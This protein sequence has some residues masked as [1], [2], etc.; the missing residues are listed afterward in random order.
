MRLSFL[1]LLCALLLP[2]PASA[3]SLPSI[4]VRDAY[5]K[6]SLAGVTTGV[7]F[8]TISSHHEDSV[9]SVS[10]PAAQSA[11]LHDH[12]HEG[13]MMRMRK[14]DSVALVPGKPV[15]FRPGGLHVMLFGVSPALKEG[16]TIALT[17]TFAHSDPVTIEV[18]VREA[19]P[20]ADTAADAHHHH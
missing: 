17:F 19:A 20:A 7:V 11:E 16:D 9:L 13:G 4:Q 2:L 8:L 18:P 1:P 14:V 10:T 5:A 12:L 15:V 6:P 3:S